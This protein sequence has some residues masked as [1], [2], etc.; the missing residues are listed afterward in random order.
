M[1]PGRARATASLHTGLRRR[2][3][4]RRNKRCWTRVSRSSICRPNGLRECFS[5]QHC[6]QSTRRRPFRNE[7]LVDDLALILRYMGVKDEN[8]PICEIPAIYKIS[9][10][11]HETR[12]RRSSAPSGPG[13]DPM[14]APKLEEPCPAR[15]LLP[16]SGARPG[17]GSLHGPP[18][19]PS[20]PGGRL[21]N[22]TPADVYFGRPEAILERRKSRPGPFRNAACCIA[23][24]RHGLKPERAKP[25]RPDQA[26][27][28]QITR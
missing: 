4:P 25:S 8:Q 24:Q 2:R 16:A 10:G 15:E 7:L 28:T 21:D 1:R 27:A 26:I 14:L 19:P 11:W 3:S 17:P 23:K 12:L 22:L 6:G 13:Q 20:P 18:Q 9:L 5:A